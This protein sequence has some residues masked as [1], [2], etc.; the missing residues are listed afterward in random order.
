MTDEPSSFDDR[1]GDRRED[2]AREEDRRPR[3][4]GTRDGS[5]EPESLFDDEYDTIDESAFEPDDP[6][7][8]DQVIEPGSIDGENALFVVVGVVAMLALFV[9]VATLL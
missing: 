8:P 2:A 1:S 9:H 6:Y 3:D 5:A 4:H 7:D